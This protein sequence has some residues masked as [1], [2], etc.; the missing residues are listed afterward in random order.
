MRRHAGAQ[1]PTNNRAKH[2]PAVEAAPPRS[3]RRRLRKPSMLKTQ[4]VAPGLAP[5]RRVPPT[6]QQRRRRN[7]LRPVVTTAQTVRQALGS[8]RLISL[9]MLLMC[10]YA[11]YLI[12]ANDYFFLNTIEVQG[13]VHLTPAQIVEA[14]QLGGQHIFAANPGQAAQAIS[15][16]PGVRSATVQLKWPQEVL[17]TIQEEEPVAV[18]EEGD[19]RYWVNADGQ[20]MPAG[21]ALS[22]HLL[23]IVAEMPPLPPPTPVPAESAEEAASTEVASETEAVPVFQP[24]TY[25]AFVPQEVLQGAQQLVELRPNIDQL[26]YTPYGGL[27]YQDGRG[28]RVYFGVGPDMAEKLA[29][30]ETIVEALLA[31]QIAPEYIHVNN[32]QRPY[33]RAP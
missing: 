3:S 11:L 12:A 7:T 20:F 19:Q 27:S 31:R 28:W 8:A 30:Y 2:P 1:H 21:S 4:A 25:L 22:P 17:I 16:M 10:A 33:Y 24:Q 18:W 29:V 15:E 32:P 14:S 5:A 23:R 6:A 9:A 13:T 26:Y